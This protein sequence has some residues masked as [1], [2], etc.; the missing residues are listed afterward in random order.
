[1]GWELTALLCVDGSGMV[2][3][4]DEL[5]FRWRYVS[6]GDVDIFLRAGDGVYF[7]FVEYSGR[8]LVGFCWDGYPS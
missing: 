3:M 4:V 8:D 5:W 7:L 1:M 2:L 6:I